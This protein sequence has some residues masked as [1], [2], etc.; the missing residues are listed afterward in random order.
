MYDNI[1]RFLFDDDKT[2]L[3]NLV[4]LIC[5]LGAIFAILVY[6]IG[7]KYIFIT[8]IWILLF[9]SSSSGVI[10]SSSIKPVVTYLNRY[11]SKFFN[12]LKMRVWNIIIGSSKMSIGTVFK[13]F[14]FY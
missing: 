11:L 9:Y 10:I 7:I 1:N 14:Y 5:K 12:K 13:E 2:L 3:I 8:F 4:N 6:L